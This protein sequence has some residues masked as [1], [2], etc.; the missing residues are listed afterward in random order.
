MLDVDMLRARLVEAV[1]EMIANRF[2]SLANTQHYPS[3]F[4]AITTPGRPTETQYVPGN[5]AESIAL[6]TCQITAEIRAFK[7]TRFMIEEIIKNLISPPQESDDKQE[8]SQED[9][10]IY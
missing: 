6:T 8:S 2:A 4:Q 1:D 10:E 7:H 9:P 5:T 3:G